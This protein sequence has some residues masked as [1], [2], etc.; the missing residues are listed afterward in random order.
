MELARAEYLQMFSGSHAGRKLRGQSTDFHGSHVE[1][2]SGRKSSAAGWI[3]LVT[4]LASSIF[5]RCLDLARQALPPSIFRCF[6][7]LILVES[8]DDDLQIFLGL[9]STRIFR[10]FVFWISRQLWRMW[11]SLFLWFGSAFYGFTLFYFS[12]LVHFGICRP[13]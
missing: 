11:I 2:R 1:Q 13:T 8:F 5:R 3:C 9:M 7:D 4:E 12:S 6:L 10:H